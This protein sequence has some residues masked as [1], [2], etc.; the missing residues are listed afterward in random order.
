M[1]RRSTYIDRWLNN[2]ENIHC[3]LYIYSGF[4]LVTTLQPVLCQSSN[5][6]SVVDFL[7]HMFNDVLYSQCF[8]VKATIYKLLECTSSCCMRFYL[9]SCF[10]AAAVAR[11]KFL[12]F[13]RVSL[14]FYFRVS[15]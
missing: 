8:A 10:F 14:Y 6:F 3:V 2:K 1:F 13:H 7:F 4:L 9:M 15:V 5:S 11:S 12:L